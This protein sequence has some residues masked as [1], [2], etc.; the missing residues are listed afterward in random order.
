MTRSRDLANLADGTEFTAADH[1]KLDGIE[2]AATADQTNAEIRAAVEA[3]TDSNVFTDADHSKLNAVEASA[4]VTDT[5]NVTAAGALM[6]SEL[7]NLAA[8]K[9]IN[10]SLV[11]T[12]SPTFAG[13]ATT[14]NVTFADNDKAIFGAGS[15]LSIY[16]SGSHSFID[17]TGTG[18]LRI[19]GSDIQL[20]KY[21]GENMLVANSDGA[22]T[23]YHD[24][25]AKLATTATGIDVTGTVTADGLTVDTADQVLINHSGDGGGIRIDST[26]AT[27][28]SS[29]RFG[30]VADNYIG[31]LE[32][33]HSNDSMAMYVNNA[34]RLTIDSSGS[35]GIGSSTIFGDSGSTLSLSDNRG[36]NVGGRLALHFTGNS[37]YAQISTNN[38]NDVVIDADRTNA[39]NA[40]NIQFRID[41][42]ERMRVTSSGN[43]NIGSSSDFVSSRLK[44]SG[45][46]GDSSGTLTNQLVVIDEQAFNTTGNGGAISFAGNF[47]NGGQTVFGTI[48]GIK[49]NNTDANFASAMTF[50][51]RANGGNLTERMRISSAGYVTTP[52]QPVF[53]AKQ[54]NNQTVGS[55]AKLTFNNVDI[56]VG[57]H[58]STSTN[59]F[60]AP[61]AG[62]YFLNFAGSINNMSSTGAYLAVYFHKNGSGTPY[63]FRT[64]A[65][66]VGGEWTGITGSAI[67]QLS[68]NDY[69]CVYGYNE[70]GTFTFQGGEHHFSGYLI[71]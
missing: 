11:T 59:R 22:V 39:G 10:Q 46:K 49:E 3:A 53:S 13:M 63:R 24:G 61:V 5:T 64:R 26:N 25:A 60:T 30:D 65:E 8:V 19:R 34:T 44:V 62:K 12:A 35:V 43:V 58:Y 7:T 18:T 55:D 23:L 2:T 50:D 28:T 31:A 68:L 56:N 67:L 47:Y 20:E 51:T 1:T 9:A 45:T 15:D 69:V 42:T 57:S 17:D 48:Q 70:T 29:L 37:G 16:H 40:S 54:T 14:A 52:N 71:G 33:N 6:D 36:S 4:D 21:T 32:Y 27:N 41:N 66:S 38:A